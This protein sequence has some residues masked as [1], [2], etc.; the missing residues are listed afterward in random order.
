MIWCISL[1]LKRREGNH[2]IEGDI[3]GGGNIYIVV[4]SGSRHLGVEVANYYQNLAYKFLNK[5]SREHIQQLI[6]E[7]KNTGRNKEI[8]SVIDELKGRVITKIPKELAYVSGKVM[9]D[10]IYDM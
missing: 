6:E 4:H 8:Q 7:Y 9:S 2:F 5:N 1:L 3:D 10:Y